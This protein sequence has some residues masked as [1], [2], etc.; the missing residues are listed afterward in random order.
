MNMNTLIRI[1]TIGALLLSFIGE[2]RAQNVL[3]NKIY[4]VTGYKKG[5]TTIRSTSNYAEVIPPLSIY[6]PSAFTP[7][8]WNITSRNVMLFCR[9]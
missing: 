9:W 5:D 1:V 7:N 8:G 4:R 2:E 3:D 6:I